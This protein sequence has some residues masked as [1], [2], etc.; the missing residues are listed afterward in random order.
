MG[1]ATGSGA[2]GKDKKKVRVQDGTLR[3]SLVV[4]PYHV[5]FLQAGEA[6]TIDNP[7]YFCLQDASLENRNTSSNVARFNILSFLLR[8]PLGLGDH[9]N[10]SPLLR[11][12]ACDLHCCLG[13]EEDQKALH[14]DEIHEAV[15]LLGCFQLA[16][17]RL[18]GRV[19]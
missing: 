4:C 18:R 5:D 1:E 3:R 14:Q 8:S 10:S 16:H 13:Q 15:W 7:Q 6:S 17:P 11:Y 2:S 9:Y 19:Q 12:T